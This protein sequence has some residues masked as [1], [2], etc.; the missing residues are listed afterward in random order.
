MKELKMKG[1]RPHGV[2]SMCGNV[3]ELHFHHII[4]KRFKIKTNRFTHL[5]FSKE[6]KIFY[7]QMAQKIEHLMIPVCF[8]CHKKLHAENYKYHMNEFIIKR[9]EKMEAENEE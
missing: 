6:G 7:N 3:K 5:L 1:E 4:P 9:Q 2:C 8:S